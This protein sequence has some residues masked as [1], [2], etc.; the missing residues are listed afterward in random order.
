MKNLYVKQ[1]IGVTIPTTDFIMRVFCK[2]K[3]GHIRIEVCE[4]IMEA[5]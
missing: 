2:D 5:H 1:V 3:R 4:R